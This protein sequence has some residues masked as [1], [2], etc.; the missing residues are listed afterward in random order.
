MPKY[1][2]IVPAYNGMPYLKTCIES[3][4]SQ[5]YGDYQLIV[6]DDH[7]TDGT[8][9]YIDSLSNPHIIKL[10]CPER[11]SMAEHWEWALSYATGEW[12]VFVGQ[13]DGLQ[14][15]FFKLADTLV[16]TCEKK[17]LEVI[18]S[19]RAY[20]FWPGCEKDFGELK[21][22][23]NARN[24]VSVLDAKKELR[25]ALY[26]RRIGYMDLPS[27]YT[28]SLFKKNFINRIKN[29]QNGRVFATHPQ[30]ANLAALATI[31]QEKYLKSWIPLGWQSVTLAIIYPRNT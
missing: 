24:K 13:D 14:S 26:K 19:E 2:I 5:G 21:L 22:W 18:M 28:T 9:E 16:L 17:G 8:A 4:V 7:S 27:M 11:K 6:S 15:Y 3:I 10:H 12:Q 25:K 20:F 31:L 23:Y 29:M 1:S 30:D